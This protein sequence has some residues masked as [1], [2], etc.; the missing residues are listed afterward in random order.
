VRDSGFRG[1]PSETHI[2]WTRETRNG[3]VTKRFDEKHFQRWADR[4]G[5]DFERGKRVDHGRG[6]EPRAQFRCVFSWGEMDGETIELGEQEWS[7][8]SQK[9]PA[10]F[11]EVDEK[12][13]ARVKG[14]DAEVVCDVVQL[15]HKGPDLFLETADGERKRLNTRKFVS[16]PHERQGES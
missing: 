8:G 13:L 10:T 5:F 2:V 14:W 3:K 16:D 7:L 9:T 4:C 12:G 11:L 6:D 1:K 15:Y